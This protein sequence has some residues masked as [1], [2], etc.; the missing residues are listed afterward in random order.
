MR[1]VLH[2]GLRENH[3]VVNKALG[4]V[5]RSQQLV[6]LPLDIQR[7]ILKSHCCD[8]VL[9]LSLVTYDSQFGP[10]HFGNWLLMEEQ[11]HI[12]SADTLHVS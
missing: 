11:G 1:E 7:G 8:V 3:N 10:I 2:E 9:L 4:E 6:N 5:E 12:Y